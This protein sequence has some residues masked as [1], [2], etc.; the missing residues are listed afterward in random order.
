MRM[1]LLPAL[2]FSLLTSAAT[3]PAADKPN[4]LI[5]LADDLGYSDLGCYGGEIATPNLDSLAKSGLRFTQAYNTA[6]C[7]PSRSALLAG[8]YAQQIHR[9]ALPSL[10]GGGKGSRQL[11]ARLLPDFLKPSGYRS[12]HS[13]KWHIDGPVLAGGFDHSYDLAHQGNYFHPKRITEDDKPLPPIAPDSSY[14]ATVA[15]ADHAI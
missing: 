13:G 14:Y 11:W 6:R 3:L 8:Y 7:W 15:T 10:Q 5:I 1:K 9:D 2:L 4:I 12:Y